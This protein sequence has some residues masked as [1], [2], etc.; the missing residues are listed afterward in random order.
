MI[1]KNFALI[2]TLCLS[3]FGQT[4]FAQT[5]SENI[6][7]QKAEL[8]NSGGYVGSES[9]S[10]NIDHLRT[11][12]QNNPNS[13]GV[14]VLY[15][16]EICKYGE[17]EAHIRGLNV[18][19]TGKGWKTSDFAILQGGYKESFNLE[20]WMVPENGGLPIPNSTIDIKN[21]IFKGTFKKRFVAYDCC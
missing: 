4:I 11:A 6:A 12:M 1:R 2:L 15:R 19:L 16:G 9:E 3:A 8:V 7:V 13:K 17:V 18:S 21:V 5:K 20:Y 14:F 10:A